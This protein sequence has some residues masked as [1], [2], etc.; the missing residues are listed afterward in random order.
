MNSTIHNTSR[1]FTADLVV[2][3]DVVSGDCFTNVPTPHGY[4]SVQLNHTTHTL[5]LQFAHAGMVHV[6]RYNDVRYSKAYAIA[7]AQRF[8]TESTATRTHHE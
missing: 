2:W 7:L 5:H 1:P 8:A 3:Q 4:V 6:R